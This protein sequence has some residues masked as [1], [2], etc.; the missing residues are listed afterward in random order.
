M[1]TVTQADAIFAETLIRAAA[2]ERGRDP[3]MSAYLAA[4]ADWYHPPSS[5]RCS[6]RVRLA[7]AGIGRKAAGR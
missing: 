3:E 1:S 2:A 6:A 5:T 7:M 4:A